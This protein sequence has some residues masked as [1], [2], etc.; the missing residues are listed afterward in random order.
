M[1]YNLQVV[2]VYDEHT[3]TPRNG[4][5]SASRGRYFVLNLS[6]TNER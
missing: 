1:D 3:E 5:F 4:R 6:S 2:F